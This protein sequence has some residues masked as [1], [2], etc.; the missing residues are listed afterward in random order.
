MSTTAATAT[1][2]YI[3]TLLR[4]PTQPVPV[5]V[6]ALADLIGRP[7]PVGHDRRQRVRGRVLRATNLYYQ[8]GDGIVHQATAY[9]RDSSISGRSVGLIAQVK[10]AVGSHID[11]EVE[12][13]MGEMES[14]WL[15]VG[16]CRQFR[17]GWYDVGATSEA[18]RRTTKPPLMTR[19]WAAVRRAMAG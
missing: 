8:T 13:G 6:R 14:V 1:N 16:R 15:R 9:L 4:P 11:V 17:D 19:C 10:L 3:D 2:T 18:R 12:N 7:K 5:E